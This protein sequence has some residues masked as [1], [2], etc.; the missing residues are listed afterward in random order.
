[1]TL[2]AIDQAILRE[3]QRDGRITNQELA[4]R[5]ELSPSPCL[6]RVRRLEEEGF[7]AGYAAI[8]DQASV[9]LAI[10]AFVRIRL[11]KHD[12]EALAEVEATILTLPNVVEAYLL[13]GDEDYLLKVATPSFENYETF[14]RDQLRR[15]PNLASVHSTFAY[16]AVKALSPLPLDEAGDPT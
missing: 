6:R 8:V 14:L 4:D 11:E 12:V 9:G 16:R 2:D 13:A 1:M 7:I 15:I 5:V 3:L 10:T